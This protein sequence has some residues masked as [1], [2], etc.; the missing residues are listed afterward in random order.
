M[1]PACAMFRIKRVST[2]IYGTTYDRYITCGNSTVRLAS[3]G[4]NVAWCIYSMNQT[5]VHQ[6]LS[7]HQLHPVTPNSDSRSDFSAYVTSHVQ[8]LRVL[9]ALNIMRITR[10][11]KAGEGMLSYIF[12][13]NK[14][15][16]GS[17]I[18][19]KFF[20]KPQNAELYFKY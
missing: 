6:Q 9:S 10:E 20:K 19:V 16:S 13:I 12:T 17:S 3:V 2:C 8:Y 7:L 11:Y 4:L 15:M 14:L 1:Y 5:L 18:R